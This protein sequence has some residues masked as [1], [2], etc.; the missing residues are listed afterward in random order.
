MDMSV[1]E[2]LRMLSME[3]SLLSWTISLKEASEARATIKKLIAL[4]TV[5]EEIRADALHTCMDFWM[6]L[7][8]RLNQPELLDEIRPLFSKFKVDD[9]GIERQ[10]RM[11]L[12]LVRCEL[13]TLTVCHMEL[14]LAARESGTDAEPC[15]EAREMEQIALTTMKLLELVDPVTDK[16]AF[17]AVQLAL[18][19][20][21]RDPT[22]KA[23][24]HVLDQASSILSRATQGSRIVQLAHQQLSGTPIR[25]ALPTD[26]ILCSNALRRSLEEFAEVERTGQHEHVDVWRARMEL[27]DSD[28]EF[29]GVLQ[30]APGHFGLPGSFLE[31]SYHLQLIH[32]LVDKCR[33]PIN[34]RPGEP[35]HRL[36]PSLDIQTPKNW[37]GIFEITCPTN[38]DI[39]PRL[40]IQA[41]SK[42]SDIQAI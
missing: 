4:A 8:C 26:G 12:R 18:W 32:T 29:F 1:S 13:R 42:R 34:G 3:L 40:D 14:E 37:P 28:R 41:P 38:L 16:G 6:A 10:L 23:T 25:L 5:D 17:L 11:D 2:Q 22:A 36:P 39:Q 30:H 21:R 7:A 27:L 35:H 31:R 33:K 24:E 20:K 9:F 19:F 15:A